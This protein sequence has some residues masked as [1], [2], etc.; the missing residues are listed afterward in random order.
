[1]TET[2][3]LPYTI[4][5]RSKHFHYQDLTSCN[6]NYFET[7]TF[8]DNFIVEHPEI[9]DSR[10]YLT[11]NTISD[12]SFEEYDQDILRPNQDDNTDIVQHTTRF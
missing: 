10:P 3:L 5:N 9:S 11:S 7:I 12:P 2:E 6:T 1:M 8:D 4:N